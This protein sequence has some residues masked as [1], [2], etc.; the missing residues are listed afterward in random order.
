[1]LAKASTVWAIS[2]T[3]RVLLIGFT[4]LRA[5]QPG[6]PCTLE[7]GWG[8]LCFCDDPMAVAWLLGRMKSKKPY[9]IEYVI[10][11][12]LKCAR[13]ARSFAI[14]DTL[15]GGTSRCLAYWCGNCRSATQASVC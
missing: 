1:M 9:C 12:D 11:C 6:L 10:I 5:S 2:L 8:E 3:F 13:F 15:F 14:V 7:G 4:L